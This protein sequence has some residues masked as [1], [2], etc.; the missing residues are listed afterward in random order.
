MRQSH[1]EKLKSSAMRVLILGAGGHGQVVA[2]ILLRM[3][4]AGAKLTPSGY[5]D[6]NPELTGKFLLGLPVLGPLAAL[7]FIPH[8]AVIVAIGNN[9]LRSRI[10]RALQAQ[11]EYLVTARHPQTTISPDVSIGPGST[12]CAGV[13]VNPGSTI[14]ANAILNTGCTVDHHNHISDHTHVAP[15]ARLG[16]DVQIGEGTLIGIGAIVM[17]QR[18]VGAWSVVGAGALVTRNLPAHVV[19]IG[20]PARIIRHLPKPATL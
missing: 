1:Y 13:I 19:A 20:A 8:E 16:G 10:F 9:E 18:S 6:D 2:D 4:A 14:G 12:I 11:G 5:L 7:P 3:Q 15:G 17:P